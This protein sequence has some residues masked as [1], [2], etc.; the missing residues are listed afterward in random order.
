M[1]GACDWQV[2]IIRCTD[3][4]LYTGIT[5]DVDRRITQHGGTRGAKYF[6]GKRPLDVVYIETGH[7]RSTASKREAAIK[8]LSRLEKLQLIE[9]RGL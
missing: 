5:V 8:K 2:Y 6:R 9:T 4:T 3:N 1:T 7:S